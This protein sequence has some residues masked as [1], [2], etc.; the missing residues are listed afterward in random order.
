MSEFSLLKS[1]IIQIEGLDSNSSTDTGGKTRLG[2][3]QKEYPDLDIFKL[4]DEQCFSIL[5]KD[6]FLKYRLNEIN[7]PVIASVLFFSL[8]NTNPLQIG[9]ICQKSLVELNCVLE[10]DGII[11]SKTIQALNSLIKPSTVKYFIAL[12]KN[13]LCDFYLELT[14]K[15]PLQIPNFR[16]WIRRVTL[17]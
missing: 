14:D 13:Y 11:G 6:Y 16:G 5:E 12:F 4:T 2:I 10:I 3:S 7:E 1:K 9:K 17:C 15:D 8:I